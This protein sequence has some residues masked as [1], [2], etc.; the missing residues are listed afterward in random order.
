MWVIIRS[1]QIRL[2]IDFNIYNNIL[3]LFIKEITARILV[4]ILPNIYYTRC[5]SPMPFCSGTGQ[6]ERAVAEHGTAD[7]G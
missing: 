1:I 4:S 3:K 5:V 6:C 2:S 7:F